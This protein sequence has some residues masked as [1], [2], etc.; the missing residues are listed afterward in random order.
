[1]TDD[2]KRSAALGGKPRSAGGAA[3]TLVYRQGAPRL[4][5]ASLARSLSVRR[6][7]GRSR[8]W[9]LLARRMALHLA[10]AGGVRLQHRRHVRRALPPARFGRCGA[11]AAA[12]SGTR[13][14]S[15]LALRR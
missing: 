15:A 4:L 6:C 11:R 8:T 9:R 5:A 10:G 2:D 13:T 7:A 1:M 3:A 14:W 12:L